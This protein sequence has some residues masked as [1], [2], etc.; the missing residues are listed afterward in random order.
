MAL[1]YTERG[2]KVVKALAYVRA[3]GI[4]AGFIAVWGIAGWIEGG[5]A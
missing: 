3:A 4:V 5:G 1:Q 2:M